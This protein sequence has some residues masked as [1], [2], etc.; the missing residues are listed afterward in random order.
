MRSRVN[1]VCV[2]RGLVGVERRKLLSVPSFDHTKATE[3]AFHS[4][5]VAMVIGIARHKAVKTK[6][7]RRLHPLHDV[8]RERKACY[9]GTTSKS[10]LQIELCRS[11]VFD[12]RFSAEI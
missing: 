5:E 11:H 9:P 2:R 12:F 6:P 1:V 7:I 10:V 3:L 8:Y 4:V